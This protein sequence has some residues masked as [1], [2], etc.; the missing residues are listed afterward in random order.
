MRAWL[1]HSRVFSRLAYTPRI[2][3]AN[4]ENSKRAAS[5]LPGARPTRSRKLGIEVFAPSLSDNSAYP[6]LI[7][8]PSVAARVRLHPAPRRLDD[9]GQ[10]LRLGPPSQFVLDSV[11]VGDEDSRV[12]IPPR[13]SADGDAAPGDFARRFDY[14]PHGVA[15]AAATQIINSA[16]AARRCERQNVRARQVF[17]VNVI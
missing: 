9:S 14:L 7:F 17:H 1:L 12:S 15:P 3:R 10:V 2:S 13:G 4:I 11:G 8:G 6:A 16:C 5:S